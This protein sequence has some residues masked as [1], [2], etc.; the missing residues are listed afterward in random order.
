MA[1]LKTIA[2]IQIGGPKYPSKKRINL[3]Q[4]EFKKRVIAAQLSAFA[5]FLV[6]LYGFV[7]VGIVMPLQEAERVE[8]DYQ[9][10]EKQLAAMKLANS[11]MPEVQEAYA[12]YGSAWQNER[13]RQIP[14][15]LAITALIKDRVFPLCKYIPAVSI[16][17][18]HVE[19]LCE[20]ERGSMLAEL[21][22]QLEED[23]S[24]RYVTASL[25]ASDDANAAAAFSTKLALNKRVVAH[26]TVYFKVP[27]ESG[28]ENG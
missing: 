13:E 22:R 12:H 26:V 11:V 16:V 23:E 1:D 7:Q 18:D 28:E 17:D 19:F 3:Y 15:R 5:V 24:V 2:N 20:L 4:R 21:V 6:F 14:D 10:M 25:E 8:Q 9:R 27:G